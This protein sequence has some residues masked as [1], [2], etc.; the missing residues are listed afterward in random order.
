MDPEPL[1]SHAGAIAYLYEVA[2][3]CHRGD[4]QRSHWLQS[5]DPENCSGE[6]IGHSLSAWVCVISGSHWQAQ[7]MF[8]LLCKCQQPPSSQD[9][10]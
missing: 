9:F 2:R 5:L 10:G 1:S 6:M 8:C 4:W 7:S 3:V